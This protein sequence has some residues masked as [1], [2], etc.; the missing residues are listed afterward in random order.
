MLGE[1]KNSP[2]WSDDKEFIE[3][4]MYN[5]KQGAYYTPEDMESIVFNLLEDI[6]CLKEDLDKEFL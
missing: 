2:L 6:Q 4:L 3:D 1:M 5:L